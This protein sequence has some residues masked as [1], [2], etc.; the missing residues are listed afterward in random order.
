VFEFLN[1]YQHF[2]RFRDYIIFVEQIYFL[3][4]FG[5]FKQM[6]MKIVH[7]KCP[8]NTKMIET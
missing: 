7:G 2:N 4:C 1:V 5:D 8:Y 3:V 6:T